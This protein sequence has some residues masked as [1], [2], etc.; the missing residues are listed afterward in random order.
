MTWDD[1]PNWKAHREADKEH[2]DMFLP[3]LAEFA[4]GDKEALAL[5]AAR[6]SEE[7]YRTYQA[8]VTDAMLAV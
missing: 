5:Q 3:V 8:G 7:L 6:E 2:T 4:I 1:V